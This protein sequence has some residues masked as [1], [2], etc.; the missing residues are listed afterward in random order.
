MFGYARIRPVVNQFEISIYNPKFELV[1]FCKQHNIV[2]VGYRLIYKPEND[3]LCDF[4]LCVIDDP[5]TLE[6]SQKYQVS[7]S[8]LLIS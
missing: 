3:L 1:D 7:P 2:P 8:K 5:L 4:K 6:L